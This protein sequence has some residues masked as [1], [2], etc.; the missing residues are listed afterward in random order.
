MVIETCVYPKS[1]IRFLQLQS[2]NQIAESSPTLLCITKLTRIQPQFRNRIARVQGVALQFQHRRRDREG[3]AECQN[4]TSPTLQAI[5]MYLPIMDPP[6]GYEYNTKGHSRGHNVCE[7]LRVQLPRIASILRNSP[8]PW[9]HCCC[10]MLCAFT[11]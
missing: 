5:L 1:S 7:D 6:A 8:R 2:G 3:K 10:S 9:L 4:L 11:I